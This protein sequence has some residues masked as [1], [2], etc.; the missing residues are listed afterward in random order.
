MNFSEFKTKDVVNVCDGRRLGRPIDIIFN[1]HA[2]I[3]AIVVPGR[4][5]MA[6]LFRPDREGIAIG[7]NRIRCI[8]SDVILVE[9]KE[10][11]PPAD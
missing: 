2:M 7:W 3:E 1:E 9:V 6:T 8:G 11:F 10:E 4:S 5:G